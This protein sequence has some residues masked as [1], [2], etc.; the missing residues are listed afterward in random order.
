MCKTITQ[1][2]KF[3]FSGETKECSCDNGLTYSYTENCTE[4]QGERAYRVIKGKRRYKCPTCSG[5][6]Y[7][8]LSE[9]KLKGTCTR[10]NGTYKIPRTAY[11]DS[12]QEEKQWIFDNLFNFEKPYTGQSSNFNEQYLG[13]GT[14]TGCTDYGRNLKMTP[15]EFKKEVYNSWMSGYNQPIGLVSKEGYLPK[16]VLMRRHKNGWTAYPIY[17]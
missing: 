6:G 9:R 5:R 7:R 10:C 11:D 1:E 2:R 14:Y 4:C 17:V 16:E 8:M 13:L 12:S 15:E 3:D